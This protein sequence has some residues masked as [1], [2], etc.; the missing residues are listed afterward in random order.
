MHG[1]TNIKFIQLFTRDRQF[2]FLIHMSLVHVLPSY[3][4]KIHF[5][6]ILA[7]TPKSPKWSLSFIIPHQNPVCISLPPSQAVCLD[8]ITLKFDKKFTNPEAPQY[9]IYSSMPL[10][11]V[12]FSHRPA[13]LPQHPIPEHP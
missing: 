9:A 1:S 11:T 8:F 2:S 10:L 3:F 6:M 12:S 4:F 5:N 7:S 13:C